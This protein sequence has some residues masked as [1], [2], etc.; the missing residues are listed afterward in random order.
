MLNVIENA[1]E[2]HRFVN[3]VALYLGRCGREAFV[4]EQSRAA[5]DED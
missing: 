1:D 4:A 2:L 5:F 3:A